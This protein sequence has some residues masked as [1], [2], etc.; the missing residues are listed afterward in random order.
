M[1]A[2]MPERVDELVSKA[3]QGDA[4]A[5]ESLLARYLPDLVV[6]IERHAARSVRERESKQDLAQSVCREVLEKLRDG[7]LAFRG[8][9]EFR[10]WLYRAA[11]LKLADRARFW[12]AERRDA[13]R[14][15]PIAAASGSGFHPADPQTPSQ[16][17]LA[18]EELARFEEAVASLPERSRE[19]LALRLV[20][21][22]SHREM[23]ERLAT[24]EANSRML[25][26]R[27]LAQLAQRGVRA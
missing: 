10:Q 17:A 18:H 13:G 3:S 4:G 7:R 9:P 1:I 14:E 8:E 21:G 2:G 11:V 16:H 26:S 6:Y 15:Q 5:V 27:A 20:E 24:S 23:A 22:L 12:K 19:V 25:L